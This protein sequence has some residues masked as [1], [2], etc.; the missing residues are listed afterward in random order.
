MKAVIFIIWQFAFTKFNT[1]DCIKSVI[2]YILTTWRIPLIQF[3]IIKCR[4]T[5]DI[6]HS[7]FF[8]F[9]HCLAFRHDRPRWKFLYVIFS[10]YT[11]KTIDN[12]RNIKELDIPTSKNVRAIAWP[13]SKEPFTQIDFIFASNIIYILIII[14]IWT[15]S[16]DFSFTTK[17]VNTNSR[18]GLCCL[19]RIGKST[20]GT[21]LNVYES[22]M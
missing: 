19:V 6:I 8:T 15:T 1:C 21:N 7:L 13:I 11:C 3:K 18:Y 22:N 12:V 14:T 9:E 5:N 4:Y 17:S 16:I 2:F 10:K 20:F